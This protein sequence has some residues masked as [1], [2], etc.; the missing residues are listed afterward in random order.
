MTFKSFHRKGRKEREGRKRKGHKNLRTA[1]GMVTVEIETNFP[2]R[3]L[4][5]L[6]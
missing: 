4:R 5:P 1:N 3:P 6:R 2:L